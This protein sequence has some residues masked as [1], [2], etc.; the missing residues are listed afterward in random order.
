MWVISQLAGKVAKYTKRKVAAVL[1]LLT[2]CVS[3]NYVLFRQTASIW[4]P[5]RD[6]IANPLTTTHELCARRGQRYSFD[7]PLCRNHRDGSCVAV[8]VTIN[9]GFYDFFVNW[10]RHFQTSSGDVLL[11]VVAEDSRVYQKLTSDD[12]L[13]P[14][15]RSDAR[16]NIEVVLGGGSE[17]QSTAAEEFGTEGYRLLVSG[18]ATHLLNVLCGLEL[19]HHDQPSM[20]SSRLWGRHATA[21]HDWVLIYTDIDALWLRN[22][23]PIVLS[24]LYGPTKRTFQYDILAAIDERN[25]TMGYNTYYCTGFLVIA[26]S[27]ASIAFLSGWE[28]ALRAEPTFNQPIFNMLLPQQQEQ[29]EEPLPLPLLAYAGLSETQFV[30][31]KF[32]DVADP[33]D[34]NIVVLHNNF[35]EG[36]DAKRTRFQDKGLWLL[37]SPP[38]QEMIGFEQT[39]Q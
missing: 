21:A 31:G 9:M 30:S 12:L 39:K 8:V 17:G 36:K 10:F 18:R 35:V 34:E 6:D 24:A 14:Q 33:T 5:L 23:I 22:P 26:D 20:L 3:L 15:G 19:N 28:E 29:Q 7:R 37:Y 25:N 32:W 13:F 1:A 38:E 4:P 27:P 16:S 2:L 11:V